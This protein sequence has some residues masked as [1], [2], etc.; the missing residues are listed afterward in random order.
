MTTKQT[1]CPCGMVRVCESPRNV[2]CSIRTPK[3]LGLYYFLKLQ[4][5]E[6]KRNHRQKGW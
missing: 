4:D 6:Q 5:Y 2:T 1:I 3:P